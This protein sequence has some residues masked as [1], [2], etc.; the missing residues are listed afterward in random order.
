MDETQSVSIVVD[1]L[2]YC[3]DGNRAPNG[4]CEAWH[5]VQNAHTS[6]TERIFLDAGNHAAWVAYVAA[7]LT[8]LSELHKE[9]KAASVRAFQRLDNQPLFV[10][11]VVK[12]R[13]RPGECFK[14]LGSTLGNIWKDGE[15]R[16]LHKLATRSDGSRSEGAPHARAS[17]DDVTSL[18]GNSLSLDPIEVTDASHRPPLY[19]EI[20]QHLAI[21]SQNGLVTRII[22]PQDPPGMDILSPTTC[23]NTIYKLAEGN[24]IAMPGPTACLEA[25]QSLATFY[26]DD[27]LFT[28]ASTQH[29]RHIFSP[30]LVEAVVKHPDPNVPESLL[31]AI[32]I[33][34]P[35]NV[36]S[37]DMGCQMTLEIQWSYVS[38]IALSMFGVKSESKEGLWAV[39]MPGGVA[40]LPN[41]NFTFRGGCRSEGIYEVFGSE[42]ARNILEATDGKNIWMVVSHKACETATLSIPLEP[43][44]A[45]VIKRHLLQA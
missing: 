11:E 39:I 6:S 14:I 17:S 41:P 9:G 29:M 2:F 40:I 5:L 32:P 20:D 7:K 27:H 4:L 34:F 30:M 21:A 36:S 18:P 24:D 25:S 10:L 33:A 3:I 35:S 22:A 15:L 42:M 43:R 26:S 1:M 12:R 45:S 23:G 38:R 31:A 19:M 13:M 37:N 44:A 28:N 16:R 8:S